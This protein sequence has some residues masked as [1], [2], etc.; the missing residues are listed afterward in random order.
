MKTAFAAAQRY[1]I[2]QDEHDE[3]M[4]SKVEEFCDGLDAELVAL[5]ARVAELEAVLTKIADYEK[6][7]DYARSISRVPGM[8][9]SQLGLD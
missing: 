2:A 6:L 5:R 4:M 9:E 7:L 3:A 8:L 1:A